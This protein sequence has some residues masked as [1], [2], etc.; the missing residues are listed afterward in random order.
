MGGKYAI[1]LHKNGID[2]I[3]YLIGKLP[4]NTKYVY[5]ICTTSAQRLRSW[6]NIVQML[7]KCFVF[8]GCYEDATSM[9]TDRYNHC[10]NPSSVGL[11]RD[12]SAL[13]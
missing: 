8:A 4:A 1:D 7:Y 2:Y 11:S 13:I 12:T 5:Y 6:S 3:T 10:S 9:L